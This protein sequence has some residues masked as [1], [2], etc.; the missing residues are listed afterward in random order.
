[1]VERIRHVRFTPQ[2]GH[3]QRDAS[4][5]TIQSRGKTIAGVSFGIPGMGYKNPQTVESKASRQILP[6]P[7][8]KMCS[9]PPTT[10]GE[11]QP[12]VEELTSSLA[13][14]VR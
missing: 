14:G 6:E 12:R 2:S 11:R 5:A 10:E 8:L 4:M 13:V 3:T 9:A 1:M 7:L